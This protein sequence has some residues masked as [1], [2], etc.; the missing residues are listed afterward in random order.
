MSAHVSEPD[1]TQK[2]GLV[3]FWTGAADKAAGATPSQERF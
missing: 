2:I 1:T 3:M